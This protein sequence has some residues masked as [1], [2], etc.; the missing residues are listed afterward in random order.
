MSGTAI[1]TTQVYKRVIVDHTGVGMESIRAL[2][3]VIH[4]PG[5]LPYNDH[6]KTTFFSEFLY[7]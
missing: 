7:T 4:N 6:H 1:Y 5:F 2:L 3:P